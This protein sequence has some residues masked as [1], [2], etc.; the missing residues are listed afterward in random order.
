MKHSAASKLI[1]NSF[2]HNQRAINFIRPLDFNFLFYS[3]SLRL[4]RP[5]YK[6]PFLI[7]FNAIIFKDLIYH[8]LIIDF[9]LT[10]NHIFISDILFLL[11][12]FLSILP[13]N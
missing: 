11:S 10:E 3:Q 4:K 13:L 8:I 7:K 1:L 5:I 12:I 9:T 2:K 6:Y